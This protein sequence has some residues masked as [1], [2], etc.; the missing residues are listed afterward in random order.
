MSAM[1]FLM[2][3]TR[4]PDVNQPFPWIPFTGLQ[5]PTF[6][7]LQLPTFLFCNN[8]HF[9]FAT[10]YIFIL[11]QTFPYMSAY[12]NLAFYLNI[13]GKD[14]FIDEIDD[15]LDLVGLINLNYSRQSRESG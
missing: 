4:V 8:L 1:D 13:H 2:V 10:S 15:I 14:R 5:Q 6:C 9:G 3:P 7:R 12:D 11:Q